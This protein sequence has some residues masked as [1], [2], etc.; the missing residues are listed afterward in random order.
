[1]ANETKKP[2][3]PTSLFLGWLV[4][5]Q[6]AGMRG[7]QP[8]TPD[9]PSGEIVGYMYNGVQLPDINAVWDKEAYPYAYIVSMEGATGLFVSA[10]MPTV[11]SVDG[12]EYIYV[13][14]GA[15]GISA[16][17]ENAW[18]EMGYGTG[19]GSEAPLTAT[20]WS[21]HDIL[22]ADGTVYLKASDPIPVYE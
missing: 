13:A 4:G 18:G 6:I 17:V 14:D 16:L 20:V 1:M 15:V 3:D 8:V 10:D 12:V 9:E 2:I 11:V 19:G 21:N 5:R 7:K 22:N